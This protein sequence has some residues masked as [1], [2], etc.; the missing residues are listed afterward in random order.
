M[1]STFETRIRETF[2]G[3]MSTGESRLCEAIQKGV[4]AAIESKIPFPLLA[5][6]LLMDLRTIVREYDMDVDAAIADGYKL[7]VESLPR[8]LTAPVSDAETQ[9]LRDTDGLLSFTRRNGLSFSLVLSILMHD[10][11]ELSR[12]GWSLERMMKEGFVSPK[13]DGW[14]KRN[15]EPVGEADEQE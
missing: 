4:S 2:A 6:T 14:Q 8:D 12:F 9:F 7:A 11:S 5:E 3:Q 10:L 15:S 1:S 13:V